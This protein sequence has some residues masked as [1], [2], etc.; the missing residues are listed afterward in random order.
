M[1]R[2]KLGKS[3]D[4]VKKKTPSFSME[5]LGDSPVSRD[6]IEGGRIVMARLK[7]GLSARP[8]GEKGE[9]LA[10]AQCPGCKVKAM[11]KDE[12]KML[13]VTYEPKNT[14][15][16]CRHGLKDKPKGVYCSYMKSALDKAHFEFNEA[17][18]RSSKGERSG[19]KVQ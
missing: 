15:D 18:Y 14:S 6:A 11:L 2:I 3:R 17:V 12:G 4:L 5:F 1:G 13:S 16:F 7:D 19:D 10:V 8:N 9:T